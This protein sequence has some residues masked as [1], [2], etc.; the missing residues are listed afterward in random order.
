MPVNRCC[1]SALV[2]MGIFLAV[3][4]YRRLPVAPDYTRHERALRPSIGVIVSGDCIGPQTNMLILPSS[5]F[6]LLAGPAMKT[7]PGLGRRN[8][9]GRPSAPA[10]HTTPAMPF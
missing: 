4:R 2:I 5:R 9:G 8:R 7:T 3:D 10:R 6:S 1:G